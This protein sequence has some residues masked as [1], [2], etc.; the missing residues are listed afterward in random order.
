MPCTSSVP[1][2]SRKASS[3]E[4]GSTSGVS[5]IIAWRTVSERTPS[6]E[7]GEGKVLRDS[8]ITRRLENAPSKREVLCPS[9]EQRLN[10]P[11]EHTGTV[12]CPACMSQFSAEPAQEEPAVQFPTE[13]RPQG[14]GSSEGGTAEPE[15]APSWPV[16]RSNE[17]ILSCPECDQR[18]RVPLE[19][20]P[21]RS[22]CPACR[23]EFMA[24]V[25]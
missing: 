3:M 17:E 22:R 4:S 10:I 1:L 19:R 25:G 2:R 5:A 23:T 21:V 6:T 8:R 9:C 15:P 24:E 14:P 11:S 12:R 13:P 16:A 18:L 20:R 7:G